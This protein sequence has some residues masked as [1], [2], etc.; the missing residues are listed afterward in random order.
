MNEAPRPRRGPYKRWMNE[1]EDFDLPKTTRWRRQKLDINLDLNDSDCI[2]YASTFAVP[3]SS[4]NLSSDEDNISSTRSGHDY[5]NHN[6]ILSN[7][8]MEPRMEQDLE[9]PDGGTVEPGVENLT[10][11]LDARIDFLDDGF[12]NNHL[13]GQQESDVD[14]WWNSD[15]PSDSDGGKH[16]SEDSEFGE[17]LYTLH[18]HF[19]MIYVFHWM[20]NKLESW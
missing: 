2:N 19:Q 10:T 5:E 14:D 13:D 15:L 20:Q 16:N 17:V 18:V 4:E 8:A 3:S 11:K 12:V 9:Q 6:V 1:D 7:S